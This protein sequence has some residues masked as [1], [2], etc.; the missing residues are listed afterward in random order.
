VIL[1]TGLSGT[2][3][4]IAVAD[5]SGVVAESVE[6]NNTSVRMITINP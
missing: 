4:I 5:G 6:T 2:Y 1:P 3:Y